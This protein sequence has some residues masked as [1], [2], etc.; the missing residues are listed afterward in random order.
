MVY[1]CRNTRNYEVSHIVNHFTMTCISKQKKGEQKFVAFIKRK[2]TTEMDTKHAF[3]GLLARSISL[4][5]EDVMES[6]GSII[7]LDTKTTRQDDGSI[8]VC[9]QKSCKQRPLPWLQITPPYPAKLNTQSCA[10]S[11]ITQRTFLPP[12]S[13]YHIWESQWAAKALTANN[14][15]A[16]F[17]HNGRQPNR[18]QEM[19]EN[20]QRNMVI[21]PYTNGFSERITKTFVKVSTPRSLVSLFG[22]SQTYLKCQKTRWTEKEASRGTVYKIKCKDYDC[23]YTGQTSGMLK[24]HR[25]EHKQ[26]IATLDENSL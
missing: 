26:A 19:N 17:I 10:L 4:W 20:D 2:Y 8:T 9:L 5:Y 13:K 12:R 21:L 6:E 18:Q 14:Y 1:G 25:K 24:T 3:D 15:P 23:V 22:Q 7:F 11:W 16:K